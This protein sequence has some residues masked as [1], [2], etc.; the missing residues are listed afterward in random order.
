L[1]S[2]LVIA[3]RS[4]GILEKIQNAVGGVKE[5]LRDILKQ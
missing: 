4:G 5:T 3:R 1:A 2:R